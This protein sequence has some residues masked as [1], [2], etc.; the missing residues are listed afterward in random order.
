MLHSLG[1]KNS[2][3]KG[4]RWSLSFKYSALVRD[5]NLWWRIYS[6]AGKI[7]Q[8][9]LKEVSGL[10]I[11]GCSHL[12]PKIDGCSCNRQT[13]SNQGPEILFQSQQLVYKTYDF[14]LESFKFNV[15]SKLGVTR[16]KLEKFFI[17]FGTKMK[18]YFFCMHILSLLY[19]YSSTSESQLWSYWI[20]H[21][22]VVRVAYCPSWQ[23]I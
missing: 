12:L 4:L 19:K 11:D 10:K 2:R 13:S 1:Q 16:I 15:K 5:S 9:N 18:V 20:Q 14:L 23:A 17:Y 22:A 21:R 3:K 7:R 6:W 8:K